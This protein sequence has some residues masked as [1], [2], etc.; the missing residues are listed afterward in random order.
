MQSN[1]LLREVARQA[2]YRVAP[3]K[4]VERELGVTPDPWQV[5]LLR[6][7][8]GSQVIALTGRQA[9]K[10]QTAAWALAHV[11]IFRKGSLSVV[12]CP[13]Q[14]QSGEAI[15]RVKAALVKAGAVLKADN[16]FAV[17]TQ[18][19]SRVL[20]LPGDEFDIPRPVRRWHR[21][22]RRSRQALRRYDRRTQADARPLCRGVALHDAVDCLVK[23][24]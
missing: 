7:P 5:E 16:V 6:S 8:P 13:S 10:T 14:R 1:D 18:E 20:A 19:G 2:L 22:R 3:D 23:G 11:A 24:R 21:L 12:A 4:W 15:R 9:G 17:E